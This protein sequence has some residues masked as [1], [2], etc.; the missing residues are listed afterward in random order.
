MGE[1][2][3]P[4]VQSEDKLLDVL[5]VMQ[6]EGV[7]GVVLRRSGG[8]A[9]VRV[10]ELL[11]ALRTLGNVKIGAIPARA[12]SLHIPVPNV[13]ALVLTNPTLSQLFAGVFSASD[14][15]FAIASI[16]GGR[17]KVVTSHERWRGIIAARATLCRCETDDTHVFEPDELFTPGKCNDDPSKVDCS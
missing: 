11:E 3:L 14:V 15:D 2:E 17:A 13:G 16:S 7:S 10:R 6:T 8:P 5:Q 9:V 4:V 1:L 12:T